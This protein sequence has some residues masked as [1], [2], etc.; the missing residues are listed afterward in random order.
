[1]NA[2]YRDDHEHEPREGME[3]RRADRKRTMAER[4]DEGEHGCYV[5]SGCTNENA[6]EFL[7]QS[8]DLGSSVAAGL[9]V[10]MFCCTICDVPPG[11][12]GLPG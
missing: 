11:A 4:E 8:L 3:A 1:M 6:A 9:A 2:L 7:A 5:E 12:C 10:S